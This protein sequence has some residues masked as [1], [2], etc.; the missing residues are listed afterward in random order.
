MYDNGGSILKGSS[1]SGIDRDEKRNTIKSFLLFDL[2]G[3]P[4]N[5]LPM[6]IRRCKRKSK[7][8][9]VSGHQRHIS[10]IPQKKL[11][12]RYFYKREGFMFWNGGRPNFTTST[13]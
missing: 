8:E 4:V 12:Q 13:Q 11:M 7:N 3:N 1:G 2:S 5:Y 6:G 10:V 9:S